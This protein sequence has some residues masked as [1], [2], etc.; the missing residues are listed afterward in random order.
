MINKPLDDSLFSSYRFEALT[1]F[2]VK[3]K[4]ISKQDIVYFLVYIIDSY[5]MFHYLG[6]CSKLHLTGD[7][8][9]EL[10]WLFQVFVAIIGSDPSNIIVVN[11]KILLKLNP[12]I[13]AKV[14]SVVR[15][16]LLNPLL[17]KSGIKAFADYS[18]ISWAYGHMDNA[19][20]L[21][22]V[23]ASPFVVGALY[24]L[25][26]SN[27]RYAFKSLFNLSQVKAS[28]RK[29]SLLVKLPKSFAKFIKSNSK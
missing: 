17:I 14:W 2:L 11:D 8:S 9:P 27:K 23:T 7:Y 13:S 10:K 20:P 19:I 22:L 29:L 12:K 24:L 5:G 18:N 26:P 16:D 15:L 6:N 4:G 25:L 1:S 3:I 21:N 28:I